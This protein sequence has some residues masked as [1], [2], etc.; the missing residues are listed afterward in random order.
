MT[1]GESVKF[2][3]SGSENAAHTQGSVFTAAAA[4]ANLSSSLG[5][6]P[7]YSLTKL[8]E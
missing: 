8:T 6:L 7:Y 1:P 2:G 5:L 4:C 3:V